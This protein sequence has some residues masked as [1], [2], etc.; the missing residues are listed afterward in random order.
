MLS[1]ELN[2]GVGSEFSV[3][4]LKLVILQDFVNWLQ[5]SPEL[6]VADSFDLKF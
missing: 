2:L 4:V 1:D 3:N 5:D 6:R